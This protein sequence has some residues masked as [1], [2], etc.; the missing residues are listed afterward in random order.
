MQYTEDNFGPEML[1]LYG[2]DADMRHDE[3]M[4]YYTEWYSKGLVLGQRNT[5][6]SLLDGYELTPESYET[7]VDSFLSN[8]I[9][10]IVK[11][12][13]YKWSFMANTTI[14]VDNYTFRQRAWISCN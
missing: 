7:F 3:F 13:V 5:I 6:C 4:L 12:M 11:P 9:S 14:D 1:E 10:F 8:F 2:A